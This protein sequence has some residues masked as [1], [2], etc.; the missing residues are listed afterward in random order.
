MIHNQISHHSKTGKVNRIIAPGLV[1]SSGSIKVVSCCLTKHNTIK[2]HNYNLIPINECSAETFDPV[3]IY[4]IL[5]ILV[6]PLG[7]PVLTFHT[8]EI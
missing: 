7:L 2:G 5:Y 8:D 4:V 1:G 6:Q 3:D